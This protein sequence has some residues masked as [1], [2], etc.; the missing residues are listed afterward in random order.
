MSVHEGSPRVPSPERGLSGEGPPPKRVDPADP[1]VRR[2][3][4]MALDRSEVV[5]PARADLGRTALSSTVERKPLPGRG[6]TPDQPA[7]QRNEPERS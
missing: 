4:R 5:D 6:E 1:R 3:A 7:K 2:V